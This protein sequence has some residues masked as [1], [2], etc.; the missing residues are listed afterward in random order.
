MPKQMQPKIAIITT[1]I[2]QFLKTN[3]IKYRKTKMTK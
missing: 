2:C 3:Q 1:K